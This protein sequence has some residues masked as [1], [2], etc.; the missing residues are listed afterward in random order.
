MHIIGNNGNEVIVLDE[1]VPPAYYVVKQALLLIP[2]TRKILPPF[3]DPD[4]SIGARLD[5]DWGW[6]RPDS[7]GIY[8]YGYRGWFFDYEDGSISFGKRLL[9]KVRD[10]YMKNTG[11]K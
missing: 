5:S 8:K 3:I 11:K 6:Y 4:V 1:T 7:Y 2:G 10:V 9:V